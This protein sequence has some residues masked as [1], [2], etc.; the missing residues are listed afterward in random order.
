VAHLGYIHIYTLKEGE[1]LLTDKRLTAVLTKFTDRICQKQHL[2]MRKLARD[3]NEEIQFGRFIRN[4]RIKVDNLEVLLFEQFRHCCPANGHLLLLEDTTPMAFS[5]E[6]KIAGLGPLDKGQIQGMYL[7]PVLCLDAATGACYGMPAVCF[8]QRTFS[9]EKLTRQQ[10]KALNYK[11]PFEDKEAYRWY[12]AIEMALKN[13]PQTAAKTVVADRESDIYAV[14]TGLQDL[15]VDYI[16][17]SR[18]NRAV[19]PANKLYALAD[20]FS[21]TYQFTMPVPATDSRSAHTAVLQVSFGQ[22]E[23]SKSGAISRQPLPSSHTCR[24]VKIV[25]EAS[26]VIGKE[27]PINWLLLTSHQVQS[28][29]QALEIIEDYR[30]RWNIEQLFR[31]LK[32]KG[33]GVENSQVSQQTRLKKLL[34]LAL[35]AAVKVLQLVRARTGTTNQTMACAFS[36]QEQE[37]LTRLNPTVEGRTEKL[38]N[39]YPSNTLA[40]AAWI[41]ARLGGWSGYQSQRPPGPIDFLI[42][43]QRFEERHQGFRLSLIT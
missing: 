42:G 28:P 21:Q 27:E 26:S 17:R 2:I 35:M 12:H 37:L 31:T 20:T 40:F 10:A 3:R 41:I 30:Q 38:K 24:V 13:C 8:H 25:E 11:T 6:R 34:L 5:L 33:L 39:P 18:H 7:H 16:I 29:Q 22:A 1:V 9:P 15:G 14:L 19:K 43:L 32:T 4:E 23:I 36:S